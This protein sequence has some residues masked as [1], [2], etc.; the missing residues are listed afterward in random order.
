[1]ANRSLNVIEIRN[2]LNATAVSLPTSGPRYSCSMSLPRLEGVKTLTRR[3]FHLH[4]TA[5]NH[6]F[7]SGTFILDHLMDG[8][9]HTTRGRRNE[10]RQG[11]S[12]ISEQVIL[13]C[14]NKTVTS[15]KRSPRKI[16]RSENTPSL[17]YHRVALRPIITVKFCRVLA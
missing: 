15:T 3:S 14:T 5:S 12:S 2:D 6:T 1:M 13:Q 8:K 17:I 9:E 7:H 10:I 16:N 4:T 11:E